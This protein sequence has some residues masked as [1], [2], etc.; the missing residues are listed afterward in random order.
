MACILEPELQNPAVKITNWDPRIQRGV[1]MGFIK[2]NS[3]QVGLVLN[4]LTGSI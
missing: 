3:T 4:P 2:T 1:N